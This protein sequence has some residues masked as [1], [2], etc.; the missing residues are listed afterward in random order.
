MHVLSASTEWDHISSYSF[1]YM[2]ARAAAIYYRL[3]CIGKYKPGE[4][5]LVLDL[6]VHVHVVH[7]CCRHL[8][9]NWTDVKRVNLHLSSIYK[10]LGGHVSAVI[11]IMLVKQ[12]LY[13]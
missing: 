1:W 12:I 11:L 10:V 3:G 8:D 7:I 13:N 4:M 5:D 2:Q 6:Y 9:R